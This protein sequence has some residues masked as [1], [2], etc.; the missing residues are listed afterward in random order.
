MLLNE[1]DELQHISVERFKNAPSE[2]Q[3]IELILSNSDLIPGGEYK[4]HLLTHISTIYEGRIIEPSN[5][6]CF[7]F[8]GRSLTLKVSKILTYP[9]DRLDEQMKKINLNDEQFY[10]ISSST[11]WCIIN[12]VKENNVVYPVT[13]VGGLS[14]VYE[15]IMNIIQK[16][17]FQS[18][19]C[20]YFCCL[21][22]F[23]TYQYII[24]V[25]GVCGIL[26]HGI[27]GTGKTLLANTV[28]HSLKRHVVEIKGWEI[29]SKIY[30]QSEAKLKL[31]FEEAMTNSPSVIL[32]DRLEILSK[33]NDSSDLERR[34]TSTL[35]TLFDLLKVVKHK[36]VA[37]LGTTSNLS[38]VDNNLRR[39]GRYDLSK[40]KLIILT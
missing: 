29:Q 30:G 6:L 32:I 23:N 20:N 34:I 3:N 28:T 40:C 38:L 21:N 8:Y 37:I 36:G 10:H 1:F 16:T 12:D 4:S 35:Q 14:D 24:I 27:S 25:L 33:S 15:K 7:D 17:K 13:N 39:P 26:L 9:N 22:V 19:C 31:L 11:T 5:F 2:A 18:M